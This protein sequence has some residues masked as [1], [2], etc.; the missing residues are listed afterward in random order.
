MLQSAMRQ[1]STSKAAKAQR[2]KP[3]EE[4]T[5]FKPFNVRETQWEVWD[6]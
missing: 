3:L 4:M 6:L 1:G 2:R 5:T